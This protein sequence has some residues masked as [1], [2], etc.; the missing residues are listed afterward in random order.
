MKFKEKRTLL[1]VLV[2]T[3]IIF[4]ISACQ[5]KETQKT[6]KTNL[7]KSSEILKKVGDDY[8]KHMLEESLYLRINYDLKIEKSPDVS[9]PKAKVDAAFAESL[10]KRLEELK[11]EELSHEESI[12]F[13]I[14]QW[15]A[16]NTSKQPRTYVRGFN[17]MQALLVLSLLFPDTARISLSTS[18]P[19]P[20][21]IRNIQPTRSLPCYN[22]SSSKIQTFPTSPPLYST[23]LSEL[24][25]LCCTSV[26][27]SGRDER[28]PAGYFSAHTQS[29]DRSCV[30]HP[31]SLSSIHRLPLQVP[32][33]CISVSKPYGTYTCIHS[34]L[35]SLFPCPDSIILK[36]DLGVISI[37]GLTSAK[38]KQ[39]VLKGYSANVLLLVGFLKYT[40]P[41]RSSEK[42]L[43]KNISEL[44]FREI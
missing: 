12:S 35:V 40:M 37:P 25:L 13:E 15:Q 5:R 39:V 4:S 33:T 6:A 24:P 1:F 28:D 7:S 36:E 29:Q 17:P 9:F 43:F 44:W 26:E 18:H 31:S 30:S 41:M 32:C 16:R 38:F 2:G 34:G 8:W 21:S 19:S 3:F 11:I 14:L 42:S 27:S 22:I 10:L 23:L 20:L